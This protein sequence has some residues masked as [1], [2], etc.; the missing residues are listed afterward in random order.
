M[1]LTIDDDSVDAGLLRLLRRDGTTS[2]FQP[3]SVW[4]AAAT[5]PT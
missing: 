4:S 2:S 5:K 1:R 3:T